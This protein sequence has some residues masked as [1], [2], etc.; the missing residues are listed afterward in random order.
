MTANYALLTFQLLA[1]IIMMYLMVH[2]YRQ[3][4]RDAA[5]AD[6]TVRDTRHDGEMRSGVNELIAELRKAADQINADITARSATLQRLIDEADNRMRA[7][8]NLHSRSESQRRPELAATRST[9]PTAVRAASRPSNARTNE[10][11]VERAN[12]RLPEKPTA[13][14][15]GIP[16][17]EREEKVWPAAPVSESARILPQVVSAS[18]AA[19]SA[20]RQAARVSANGVTPPLTIASGDHHN[21]IISVDDPFVAVGIEET[22]TFQVVRRMAKEGKSAAEIARAIQLGREEVELIMQMSGDGR[23]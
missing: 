20:Y 5:R 12:D 19:G 16:Q 17:P 11:A 22:G 4:R 8:D 14:P 18:P 3:L 15:E 2:M 6:P 7:L 1:F 10:R 23:S 13:R 9:G 21:E